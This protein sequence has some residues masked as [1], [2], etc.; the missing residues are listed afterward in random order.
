MWSRGFAIAA[1]VVATVLVAQ[2]SIAASDWPDAVDQY[3]AQVR[4]SLD[5]TDMEGYLAVVREPKGALLVDVRED[6]ELKAGH[7]PGTVH[8]SRE[9]LE[10]R[11]WK[12]LG[13]PAKVDLNRKIYVQ[14]ASGTRATLAAKQLKDLG[15]TN[16]TAVVM[17]L[18]DWRRKGYPFVTD[19]AK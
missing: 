12:P 10:F 13:Y 4:K 3:I 18:A 5:T 9:R 15:F 11:I 1:G 2:P 8:I 16:V 17:D 19:E 6:S 14:C 7:V